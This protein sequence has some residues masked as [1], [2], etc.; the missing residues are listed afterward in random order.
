MKCLNVSICRR[1]NF[2]YHYVHQF[3]GHC[4]FPLDPWRQLYL[5]STGENSCVTL[6]HQQGL[7]PGGDLWSASEDALGVGHLVVH[8]GY[9]RQGG[10]LFFSGSR[11]AFICSNVPKKKILINHQIQFFYLSK[12]II[13][14]LAKAKYFSK[15]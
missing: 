9:L 10:D 8:H 12:N 1:G 5:N 14:R 2:V 13:L 11:A 6:L 15:Y 3:I 4:L 7:F